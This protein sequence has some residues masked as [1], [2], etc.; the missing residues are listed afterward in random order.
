MLVQVVAAYT[1]DHF[2]VEAAYPEAILGLADGRGV[3]L[4]SEGP[5]TLFPSLD[6]AM[7]AAL[8]TPHPA[9]WLLA[10]WDEGYPVPDADGLPSR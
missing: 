6:A 4:P 5:D 8:G 9:P 3:L 2:P 1:T 10:A 7:A